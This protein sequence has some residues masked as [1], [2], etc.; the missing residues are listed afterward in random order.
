MPRIHYLMD[1]EGLTIA[2]SNWKKEHLFVGRNFSLQT[3]ILKRAMSVVWGDTLHLGTASNLRGYILPIRY[4]KNDTILGALVI[5][6]NID[7]V[8]NNWGHMDET[9]LVTD[10]DGVIF[11]LLQKKELRFHSLTPLSKRMPINR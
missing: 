6:I 3:P 5:K 7:S 11:F 8:E 10:P 2:A 9:F 1:S 4:G